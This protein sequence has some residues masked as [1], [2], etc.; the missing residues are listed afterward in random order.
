MHDRATAETWSFLPAT[1]GSR[2]R[3]ALSLLLGAGFTLSLFLG[4]A[5]FGKL[6]P[7]NPPPELDDL[8]VAFL[9]VQPP[10]VPV[11]PI[12]PIPD[13][14]P[15]AGFELSPSDSEV[16]IAVSPP[17]LATLLPEDLSKAP[18]ANAQVTLR[19]ADFKPRMDFIRDPAHIFQRSE[20]D[21]P[22]TV[23]SRAD[24]LVSSR[25][26]DNAASLHV[27]LVMVIDANGMGGHVRLTKS[28]GNAEF[29]ALMI[30]S[31]KEWVFT[32]AIKGGKKVRCLI[33]Q[34]IT[35]RWAG[36]SLLRL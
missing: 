10:P 5:H 36:G 18:P 30:E 2:W 19:L 32:P 33:E 14:T 25:V 27:T 4:I 22:P 23:V 11:T 15:L 34:G 29:D 28:S 17:N 24:P 3:H 7:T 9:P 26:R 6:G 20:V 35:V 31:I 21:Q 1:T 16:K 13:I 12:D 8:R